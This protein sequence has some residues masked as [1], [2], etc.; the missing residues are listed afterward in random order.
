MPEIKIRDLRVV[1]VKNGYMTIPGYDQF[2]VFS[3]GNTMVSRDAAGLVDIVQDWA[4]EQ[5]KD[6][7][8]GGPGQS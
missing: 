8:G 5:E 2:S 3:P 4:A 7:S 6:D 1:R